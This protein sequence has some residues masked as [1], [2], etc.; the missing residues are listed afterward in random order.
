MD[1]PEEIV[2][3]DC[4]QSAHRLTYPPEEGWEVGDIVAYR[5]SGCNDRW[6][7]VVEDDDGQTPDEFI[8]YA[9]EARAIMES[10][11]EQKDQSE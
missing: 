1:I 6:D 10:R 5:C 9:A 7:L 4:G 3:V 2:C 11:R 8:S